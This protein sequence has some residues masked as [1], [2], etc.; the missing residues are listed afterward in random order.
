MCGFVVGISRECNIQLKDV[1]G[2]NKVIAHRGP[3]SEQYVS[4]RANEIEK[5]N[6]IHNEK[7][8]NEAFN[9]VFGFRRLSI[10]DLS[11][12]SNQPFIYKNRYVIAF[13]GEIYNYKELK[14]E[15]EKQDYS[16]SS[17]GDI[18]VLAASIDCWN[19]DAFNKWNGM[20]SVVIYDKHKKQI[21]ATRD[22]FGIKPLYYTIAGEK[23]YFVSEIKQFLQ[24]KSIK[25][26]PNF[27]RIAK[28]YNTDTECFGMET[29]FKNIFRF[30]NAS[31]C[32]IDLT[33]TPKLNFIKYY[34]LP[35]VK[36][37][38]TEVYS[39]DKAR[40]Y[41]EEYYNLLKQSVELRLNADVDVGVC[42][43][44]GMDST[45]ITYVINDIL[46]MKGKREKLKTFSLIFKNQDS[47]NCDESTLIEELSANLNLQA[48]YTEPYLKEV[49]F[50]YD[51]MIYHMDEIQHSSLMSYVFTYKLVSEK[52]VKVTL[53]GQGADELQGGYFP[54]LIHY[55][56]NLP[57]LNIL[58]ER[59]AFTNNLEAMSY[60]RKGMLLRFIRILGLKRV[61]LKVLRYKNYKRNPFITA[62]EAMAFDIEHNLQTLLHY[63]DRGSM[64][65]SVESRFPFLDYRMVEFWINIPECYKFH[66]GYTKY[67]ARLAFDKKLPDNI[68]WSK[69]KLG[70][71]IP[72]EYWRNNG[73]QSELKKYPFNELS[74]D[75]KAIIKKS[76]GE[77]ENIGTKKIYKLINILKWHKIFFN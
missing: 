35:V 69:K 31:Y 5:I 60:V 14:A 20:W 70:W 72:Q 68:V 65:H 43:S 54:Y 61:V 46:K 21:I 77:A 73:V 44:G 38:S 15:L 28:N 71:E 8:I 62:N 7:S 52:K 56:S 17:T 41:A 49:I 75:L 51:K 64:M 76:Y 12:K 50:N 2:M 57:I 37:N 39:E 33:T 48:Y 66:N 74:S 36:N 53:D 47:K 32:V 40:N 67:I 29:D 16:F 9:L 26:S 13:N 19:L 27:E 23:I 59:K 30:P 18:E 55:F 22:R 58:K 63:G 25:T 6:D 42:L 11:D 4:I 24:N 10:V 34:E 45:S 1:I 3:D